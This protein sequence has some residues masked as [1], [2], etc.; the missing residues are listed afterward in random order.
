MIEW[1]YGSNTENFAWI[2][3]AGL[4]SFKRNSAKNYSRLCPGFFWNDTDSV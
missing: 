2:E 3:A 1:H 4:L